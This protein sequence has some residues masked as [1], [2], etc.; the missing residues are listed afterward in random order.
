MKLCKLGSNQA[1]GLPNRV[2]LTTCTRCSQSNCA[3]CPTVLC[4]PNPISSFTCYFCHSSLCQNRLPK[5]SSSLGSR[6]CFLPSSS[7]PTYCRLRVSLLSP[8]ASNFVHGYSLSM[9][10]SMLCHAFVLQ[11]SKTTADSQ[12]CPTRH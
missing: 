7:F 12:P 5:A 11:S 9:S 2:S 10:T 8:Q 4:A 1:K 6:P 3:T